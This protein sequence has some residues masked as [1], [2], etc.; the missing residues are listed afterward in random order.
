MVHCCCCL[1][2]G[3]G[4]SDGGSSNSACGSQAAHLHT[5]IGHRQA[6][7]RCGGPR[8]AHRRAVVSGAARQILVSEAARHGVCARA[9]RARRLAH[10]QQ[11]PGEQ[12]GRGAGAA[13]LPVP[14]VPRLPGARAVVQA[15]LWVGFAA[16]GGALR[17][18][19][20][21]GQAGGGRDACRTAVARHAR[22][23]GSRS[24]AYECWTRAGKALAR[25]CWKTCRWRPH[26]RGWHSTHAPARSWHPGRW[27]SS[28]T[29]PSA[30]SAHASEPAGVRGGVGGRQGLQAPACRHGGCSA[31]AAV[32][33]GGFLHCV[34]PEPGR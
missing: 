24:G 25:A 12:G 3:R 17:R 22:C 31:G 13:L 34:R 19:G 18:H 33:R 8:N 21:S 20:I 30:G 26:A 32:Q 27:L 5:G 7:A 23:A 11:L 9:G 28:G 29:I 16:P 1:S 6:A 15:D 4:T 10:R 2:S 14:R